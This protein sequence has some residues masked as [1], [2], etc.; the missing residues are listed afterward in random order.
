MVF[1][2][3]H[4]PLADLILDDR[5]IGEAPLWVWLRDG[6]YRIQ[7]KL[8][9]ERFQPV[10]LTVP[11]VASVLCQREDVTGVTDVKTDEKMTA[12]EKA[13]SVLIWTAGM[14]GTLAA[15]LIPILLLL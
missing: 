3:S 8:E 5:P 2:D 4:P 12:E 10:T 14:A 6:K 9:G 11:K 13:G 15:I 1:L 7:C